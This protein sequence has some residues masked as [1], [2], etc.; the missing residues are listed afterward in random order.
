MSENPFQMQCTDNPYRAR[1][2][3]TGEEKPGPPEASDLVV[4]WDDRSGLSRQ[5]QCA[6]NLSKKRFIVHEV[7]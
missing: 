4:S 5:Y 7:R 6:G 3:K 1:D 2:R